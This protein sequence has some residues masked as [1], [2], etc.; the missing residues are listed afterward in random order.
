[1]SIN[2][3]VSSTINDIENEDEDEKS[4]SYAYKTLYFMRS[5]LILFSVFFAFY[6]ANRYRKCW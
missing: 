1:M 3:G 4:K 2:M 5:I 6:F